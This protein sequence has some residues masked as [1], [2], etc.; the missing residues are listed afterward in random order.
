MAS[1]VVAVVLHLGQSKLEAV[2][3]DGTGMRRRV[4]LTWISRK[5]GDVPPDD[6][7]A[8]VEGEVNYQR[9]NIDPLKKLLGSFP[10]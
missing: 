8:Q 5:R 4:N 6:W 2:V 9:G 7:L 1:Q 3:D 10:T